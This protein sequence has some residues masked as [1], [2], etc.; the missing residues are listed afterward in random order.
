MRILEFRAWDTKTKHIYPVQNIQMVHGKTHAFI[1]LGEDEYIQGFDGERLHL[2][3]NTGLTVFDKVYVYEGY[4]LSFIVFDCFGNE[5]HH[6]GVVVY[7]G[8]RFKLWYSAQSE[9]Y[10]KIR[11]FDLAWVLAQDDTAKIIGNIHEGE[12]ASLKPT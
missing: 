2:M 6:K 1:A 7:S 12:Q 3:Q 9:F 8:S 11:G 10:G 5:K 4:W